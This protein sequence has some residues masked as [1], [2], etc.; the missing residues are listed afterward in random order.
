MNPWFAG[1]P[2]SFP[3][4]FNVWPVGTGKGCYNRV[5]N[6]PGNFSH[7]FEIPIRRDGKT[8]FNYINLKTVKLPGHGDF[9]FQI[10]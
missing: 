3:G 7:S 6:H 2:Q 8:S 10:H 1:I 4:S 5:F 9:F